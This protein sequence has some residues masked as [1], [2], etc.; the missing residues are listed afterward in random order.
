MPSRIDKRL[1]VTDQ[2][3]FQDVD[4][5]VSVQGTGASGPRGS[6]RGY[7]ENR[8]QVKLPGRGG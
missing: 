4:V 8:G 3:T 6:D 1:P 7:G 2:V 5:H